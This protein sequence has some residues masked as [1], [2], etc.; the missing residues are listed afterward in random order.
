MQN[1]RSCHARSF[2]FTCG[3][4]TAL[5]ALAGCNTPAITN[6]TAPSLISNPSQIYTISTRV[7]PQSAN[8]IPG[9][10]V[11]RIIIG[12]QSYKMNK[13]PLGDAIFDFD[14]QA[15][16]GATELAYYFLLE[17]KTSNDSIVAAHTEYSE[18][19][20]ANIV[21]RNVLGLTANRGPVGAR[22]GIFGRGFTGQDTV[23]FDTTP[24]LSSY[25]SSTSISFTVP[26]LEVNRNYNVSVGKAAGQMPV[27]TFR[28]DSV[29][30][31]EIGSTY[32]APAQT[33]TSTYVAQPAAP[34]RNATPT[35]VVTA[36]RAGAPSVTPSIIRMRQGEK[37]SVTFS[38]P[39][40][41]SGNPTLIE[42]TTN[43][44][45]S[46]IMPEVFVPVGSNSVTIT[47]EGGQPGNG[48]LYVRAPGSAQSATV[49]ITVLA[50]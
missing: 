10:V 49:P 31:G 18:L 30:G 20:R 26:A 8:V 36:T 22:A 41:A 9:S 17:Y 14:Y 16:S 42:V 15:A 47:V 44:P 50:R 46:V 32:V 48:Q 6:M 2:F 25:D 40:T 39:I 34:V 27:G 35:P 3:I 37:I 7:N 1:N 13:S 38:T 24:V 28:I 12:G 33:M 21:G 23:Y 11:V 19:Q 43:I 45:D 5:L 4:V 29:I